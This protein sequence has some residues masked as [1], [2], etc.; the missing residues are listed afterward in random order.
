MIVY[1]LVLAISIAVIVILA[2]NLFESGKR[3]SFIKKRI[4]L[5]VAGGKKISTS[6]RGRSPLTDVLST[7]ID[8]MAARFIPANIIKNI[9]QKIVTAGMKDINVAKYFLLKIIIRSS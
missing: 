5:T 6:D 7:K 2:V 3:S 8:R 1:G 9:E 4:S